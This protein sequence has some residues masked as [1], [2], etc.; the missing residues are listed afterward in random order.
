MAICSRLVYDWCILESLMTTTNTAA[1]WGVNCARAAL[2]ATPVQWRD[3]VDLPNG[4]AGLTAGCVLTN[5]VADYL[6]FRAVCHTWRRC[7]AYP[8]RH[9]ALDRCLHPRRCLIMFW[10]NE[11]DPPPHTAAPPL[12]ECDHRVVHRDGPL[13]APLGLS[14]IWAH[15]RGPPSTD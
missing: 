4:P 1:A 12:P 10:D 7:Y 2:R 9:N 8:R 11:E 6:C 14:R 3:W 13:G 15:Y 5:D